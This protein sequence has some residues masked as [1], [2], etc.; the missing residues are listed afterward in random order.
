MK[1]KQRFIAEKSRARIT[2]GESLRIIRE[3][4]EM[5]QADLARKTGIPQPTISAIEHNRVKLGVERAKVFA[6]ALNCHPAVLA[7]P[8]WQTNNIAA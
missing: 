1:K 8:G 4:Q 6:K 3:L 5:S 2:V 7:F